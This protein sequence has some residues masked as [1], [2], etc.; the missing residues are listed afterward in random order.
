MDVLLDHETLT[1]TPAGAGFDVA[2]I[3]AKAASAGCAFRDEARPTVFVVATDPE[4]RDTLAERRKASPDEGFPYTLL[5]EVTSEFVEVGPPYQETLVLVWRDF[6]VW[7]TETFP[8][9]VR[10]DYGTD[11]A[12][13]VARLRTVPPLTPQGTSP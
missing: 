4:R 11:M 13:E 8:C 9:S 5:I 1:F 10:N 12:E 7:L 6:I 2:A 3:E